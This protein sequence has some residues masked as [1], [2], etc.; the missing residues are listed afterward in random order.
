MVDLIDVVLEGFKR[1]LSWTTGRLNQ[2]MKTGY[3]TLS[4]SM[5]GTPTPDTS[6]HFVF[7][8]PT[9]SPWE[10]IHASLIG[11]DITFIALLLLVV[12]VQARHLLRIFSMSSAY[13]AQKAKKTAWNGAILIITWYWL[14]VLAL[15]LIDGF[16]IA[17]LPQLD[18][19]KEFMVDLLKISL[20][21][22]IFGLIFAT[23]GG[24]S[25]WT[26]QALLY[27]RELLLYVYL[28]AMPIA[29]ALSYGNV[30]ILADIATGFSRRFVPL[31]ILPLP[32]AIVLKG[33][34]LLYETGALS[35][36]TV[37]FKH[38]VAT[39]LPLIA[40]YV[41]WKTFKY[42]S[43]LTARVIGTATQ[44]AVTVGTVATGAYVAG[45]SVATT[46]ARW[47]PRAAAGQAFAQ[48]ATAY[49]QNDT[50]TQAQPSYRRTENDPDPTYQ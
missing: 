7:G 22:P 39:S 9:N 2:G 6:G 3:E 21:S 11:G 25:M 28:Y 48:R 46:A 29:F 14:G 30:P 44:T 26:L 24:L 15:Y 32:A 35:P 17:L 31:A 49:A 50:T 13:E 4:E 45:G 19:V 20:T 23:I 8:A 43:P 42:A 38:L 40:L 36:P 18:S 33:Y 1:V 27:L 16:T 12:S 10:A 37:F 34:D 5:F 47:G 41:T